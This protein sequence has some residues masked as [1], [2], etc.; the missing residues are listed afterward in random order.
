MNA[1]DG[2]RLVLAS[3]SAT[4]RALMTAAGL[5]FSVVVPGV[6]EGVIKAAMRAEGESAEAAALALADAKAAWVTDP[7]AVVIGAD[8]IL[9]CE[10]EWFDKPGDM[11]AAR[12][13]L[14]R[15]RGREHRLVTAVTGWQAGARVWCEAACPVM[16]MRAFSDGFLDWY[17]GIEADAVLASVGGYRLEGPGMQLFEAVT[18]EF[19]AV[20]GLPMMGLLGFLRGCGVVRS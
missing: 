20:L 15:L 9:V 12:A 5:R 18:G 16:R 11:A 19:P 4:R 8:Q 2:P 14:L 13:Q 6:E 3:G 1:P 17:L 10:G 7:E